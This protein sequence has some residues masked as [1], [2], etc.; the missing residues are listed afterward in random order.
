MQLALS[1]RKVINAERKYPLLM[2]VFTVFP[3]LKAMDG[4]VLH[5]QTAN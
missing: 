4:S 1:H 5:L 3:G 2:F